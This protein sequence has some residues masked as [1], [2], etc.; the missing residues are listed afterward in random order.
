MFGWAKLRVAT[1]VLMASNKYFNIV[2]II[3]N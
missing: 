1:L 3:S 2:N